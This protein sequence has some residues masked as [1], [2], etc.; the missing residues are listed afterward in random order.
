[1]AVLVAIPTNLP[2]PVI[3]IFSGNNNLS[4][5]ILTPDDIVVIFNTAISKTST[6]STL[7]TV[8]QPRDSFLEEINRKDIPEKINVTAVTGFVGR[9]TGRGCFSSSI[10]KYHPIKTDNALIITNTARYCDHL[11]NFCCNT[12]LWGCS[13][14]FQPISVK[15]PFPMLK[16]MFLFPTF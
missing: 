2:V 4:T 1:M 8:Y 3:L 15:K 10:V 16:Q 11:N 9:V 7:A 5:G 13:I 6:A 12:I 14:G